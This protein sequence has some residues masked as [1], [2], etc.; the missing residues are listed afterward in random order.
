MRHEKRLAALEARL[1]A[2]ERPA[3]DLIDALQRAF[4]AAVRDKIARRLDGVEETCPSR[5]PEPFEMLDI[6]SSRDHL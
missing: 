2:Q 4:T 5:K 1:A 6:A 3:S